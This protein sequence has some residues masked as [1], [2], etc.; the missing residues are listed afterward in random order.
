MTAEK[1]CYRCKLTKPLSAFSF[2]QSRPDGH[3]AECKKCRQEQERLYHVSG[4]FRIVSKAWYQRHPHYVW[5]KTTLRS[6]RKRGCKI[7]ITPKELGKIAEISLSCSMCDAALDWT[8]E[9]NGKL[10]KLSPTLDRLYNEDFV[11]ANNVQIICHRCNTT[12]NDRSLAEFI[13]YC[14]HI[15]SRYAPRGATLRME[16]APEPTAQSVGVCQ[17]ALISKQE[18]PTFS[19]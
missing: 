11:S 19:N 8:G 16:A 12:K 9:K 3:I 2:C 15:I 18:E 1:T 10:N 13:E 14:K 17:K 7:L 6:H 5:A 4:Q